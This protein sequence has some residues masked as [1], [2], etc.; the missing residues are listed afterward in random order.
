M[1]TIVNM[2]LLSMHLFTFVLVT[3]NNH[4]WFIN[5]YPARRLCLSKI[6]KLC[7]HDCNKVCMEVNCCIG[8]VKQR[9]IEKPSGQGTAET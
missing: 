2:V 1:L 9:A 3:V 7:H 6:T 8:S 5:I 4:C